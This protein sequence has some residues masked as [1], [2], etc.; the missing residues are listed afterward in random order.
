MVFFIN[1]YIYTHERHGS[2]SLPTATAVRCPVDEFIIIITIMYYT[3]ILL[4]ADTQFHVKTALPQEHYYIM[5]C[6]FAMSQSH[7]RS[8]H[9]WMVRITKYH[10]RI[11]LRVET[12]S[13][14]PKLQGFA[15]N[16][17]MVTVSSFCTYFLPEYY[18]SFF[19][20]FARTPFS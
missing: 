14:V 12:V 6:R 5:F 3:F 16:R 11:D 2:W 9:W 15:Y 17:I 19:F 18:Q 1:T 7:T 20:F 4:S 13:R 8:W 10:M